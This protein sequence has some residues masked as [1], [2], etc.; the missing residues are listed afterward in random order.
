MSFCL[1]INFQIYV[2]VIQYF[3]DVEEVYYGLVLILYDVDIVMWIK[4]F[5]YVGVEF[6]RMEYYICIF[7]VFRYIYVEK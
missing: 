7:Y 6:N 5:D 3:Y 2:F 4:V 1:I